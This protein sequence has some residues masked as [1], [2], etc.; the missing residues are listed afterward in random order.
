MILEFSVACLKQIVWQ[1]CPINKHYRISIQRTR[2]AVLIDFCSCFSTCI[3]FCYVP[4]S[5]TPPLMLLHHLSTI[6]HCLLHLQKLKSQL[7]QSHPYLVCVVWGACPSTRISHYFQGTLDCFWISA[8]LTKNH[9]M[10]SCTRGYLC[11]GS[12]LY[13][14]YLHQRC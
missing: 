10:V 5:F 11:S 13:Y 9:E 6:L 7:L 4:F 1:A 12:H 2:Q 14:P 3:I 8:Q